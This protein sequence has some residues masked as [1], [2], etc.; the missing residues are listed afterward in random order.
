MHNTKIV[1]SLD[2]KTPTERVEECSLSASVSW[3]RLKPYI[4]TAIGDR[5]TEE[6]V[7]IVIDEYG[8]KVKLRIV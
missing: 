8:I 1:K 2:G 4:K 5:P 7:G 6:I 3:E